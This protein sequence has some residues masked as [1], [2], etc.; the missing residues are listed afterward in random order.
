[1][2][3]QAEGVQQPLP[4]IEL[5]PLENL[6]QRLLLDVKHYIE[7]KEKP[8]GVKTQE[9]LVLRFTGGW[10]RDKLLGVSSHDIDVAI[11]T[12][13]GFQFG[14][15]LKE[16]LDDPE[17]LA[18]YKDSE[19]PTLND[20]IVKIHKIDAN[21]E[22]SKHLETITTKLFG[23]DI[24]LV[25]LRKETYTE[26]SRNPQMEFG[27]A[28]EDA[29]RRDAT[30]NA[31][32]YNLNTGTLEDY[33]GKGL[34]D[35]EQ[36]LIRTP[37]EAYQTF[38]DDPL[39]VLRLIR[40]ASRLGYRIDDESQEAMQNKD[41]KEAL[42]LKIS[43]ERVG[44]EVEKMLRGPDPKSALKFIDSLSLYSTIFANQRDDTNTT[45]DSWHLVYD[46]FDKI[47]RPSETSDDISQRTKHVHDILIRDENDTY[48]AWLVAAFAPWAL[49]P[50]RETKFKSEKP[51]VIVRAAEVARDNLRSENKVVSLLKDSVSHF[52]EMRIFKNN[53][54]SNAIP[55]TAP[56]VR[57]HVGLT[58]RSWRKDWRM[59][60]VMA[61]LQ[62]IM[63][64]AEFSTVILE[65]DR[66]LSYLETENLLDVTDLRPIVNGNEISAALGVRSGRWLSAALE[67]MIEWQLLHPEI[68]EK[69]KAL[70]ENIR[71]AARKY[72]TE[73]GSEDLTSFATEAS[74]ETVTIKTL[75]AEIT[76]HDALDTS[77]LNEDLLVVQY[78]LKQWSSS[79]QLGVD[80]KQ[81]AQAMYRSTLSLAIS[82]IQTLNSIFPAAEAANLA[83]I[84]T[85]L[86]SFTNKRD[87]WTTSIS[88]SGALAV[89]GLFVQ[90]RKTVFWEVLEQIC[91]SKIRP[92]F[93]KTKTPA[94]TA[95]GRK[96]LHPTPQPRFDG[97][98]FNPEAKPWKHVNVYVT[99]VLEWLLSEYTP[100]D[101]SR[102]E[103][104]FH[105]YIPPILSLLDD[106]SLPFKF[107]GCNLLFS[108]LKPIQPSNSDLL[109]RTNL[110]S[111]FDDALTP[112][113]LSLP[114]I[115]PEEESLQLL[116]ATYEAL[117]LT[118]QTR[119]HT[120]QNK[121]AYTSRITKLLRDNIISSF[122]HISSYT[123]TSMEE[124]ST[125]VSFPYPRLS[126]FILKELRIIT[127]E[128]GIH[129]SKY[130]QEIVPMIYST[131]TNPFGTAHPPL[132][133]AGVAAAQAVIFNSH[134]R[135][136]RYRGELLS[137]FCECWLHVYQDEKEMG[138]PNSN[139]RLR[140]VMRRL[141]GAV[142]LLKTAV[143]GADNLK[144]EDFETV[145]CAE[146]EALIGADE[147]LKG[148]FQGSA[149]GNLHNDYFE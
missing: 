52:E 119:Y 112:N 144:Q 72:I 53:L 65:Y 105:F 30:V 60:A 45:T 27:T 115:T 10:V 67:M 95:A 123:P 82:C 79:G 107:R 46:A 93:A 137:A 15:L 81:A 85:A 24:D 77:T 78:V 18:K 37:L 63:A 17:N 118:I 31:M 89:L 96:N 50:A 128:L 48:H 103:S 109:Q 5:T 49:V 68:T 61:L 38:K 110:S 106:E 134:P 139:S 36:K 54:I 149:D 21:P 138:D 120:R 148:L 19:N 40:F 25:N 121:A 135:I 132:L 7:T 11:S 147:D 42:K 56:E 146:I 108:F 73:T 111:V 84:I 97:N 23:L 34:Q 6:I 13:T 143:I 70:Q 59:I 32:F 131:L 3:V 83:D 125:L 66:F 101:A 87:P 33:T 44:A 92:I 104:D 16:Y 133:E 55:G 130:L 122:H 102:L 145:N 26:E 126:T 113:L 20:D 136:W 35:L 39:R 57:Q 69:E 91:V 64:G 116:K 124:P 2:G 114:K 98:I 12:M 4:R 1:M 117:L 8:E 86:A 100:S 43:K 94:I 141:Q 76:S 29:L 71:L 47:A 142:Y 51:P 14:S 22:K 62:E 75:W 140:D 80:D 9:E 99:T 28:E 129:T 88:Y 74:G 58:I 41:I 90:T 127:Q